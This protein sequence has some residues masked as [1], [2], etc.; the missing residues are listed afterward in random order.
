MIKKLSKKAIYIMLLIITL[1]SSFQGIVSATEISNAFIQYSHDCGYHLQYWHN[2]KWYYVITSYV[3]YTAPNGNKYPAYCLNSD[4]AGASAGLDYNVS[5]SSVLDDDRIW[6]VITNGYPYN[7]LGLN[8]DDA[9]VATKHAVYS[10]IHNRDVRSYYHG[11][12]ER[13]NAIVDKI[14]YLVNIGRYGTAT[15][16]S[17]QTFAT[18]IGSFSKFN[19]NY[20]AQEYSVSSNIEMSSYVVTAITGFP[21]NSYIGDVNGNAKTSFSAGEH[22]KIFVPKSEIKNNFSGTIAL[23]SKCKT[24]PVF[25]GNSPSADLQNY[26]VC[27]DPY[28]DVQGITTLDVNAYKSTVK[29]H[30]VDEETK[31]SLEGITF[32][33]K[34][35]DTG[36]NIGDFK[37]DK[38]GNIAIN[39]LRP[40]TILLTEKSTTKHYILNT[41]EFEISVEFGESKEI[42]ISNQHKKGNLR[43]FKVDKDN[44]RV[45]LGNVEFDL[46]SEEY[47]KV[48]GTY[49]TDV[50]RRNLCRK[51]KNWRL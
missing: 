38:N 7:N 13:G 11:G 12:D 36:E 29:I 35:K 21:N 20:Y 44:N 27:Y 19:N 10:I 42:E 16:N 50:N 14:E 4:R 3:E 17:A 28:G 22:F 47:Q 32:N 1:L 31:E 25:Y 30:K 37:T 5:I 46:Y 51:F 48:I 49:C 15:Q 6:R 23:Q 40:S 45:A 26:A 41:K 18:K 43:V 24:F 34:Y 33:A 39:N 9:F 8:N 2:N